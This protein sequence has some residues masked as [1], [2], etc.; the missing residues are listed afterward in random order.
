MLR[1][2]LR[3]HVVDA[4]IRG[5]GLGHLAGI[6]RDHHGP[7]PLSPETGDR[8]RR[9]LDLGGRGAAGGVLVLTRPFAEQYR[10]RI[11]SYSGS[12]LRVRTA[13]GAADVPEVVAAARRI[14]GENDSFDTISLA[15]E[16]EAARSA[17]DV[18]AVALW[19]VAA[20][21]GLAGAVAVAIAL[22]RYMARAS[23]DQDVLRALGAR[24]GERW[25]ATFAT[26]VP[27]ALPGALVAGIAAWLASPLFP[28]GVARDAEPA[29]QSQV[30]ATAREQPDRRAGVVQRARHGSA[31]PAARA[32]DERDLA[33]K[34]GHA[35][36]AGLRSG[37]RPSPRSATA[38]TSS[39]RSRRG[40]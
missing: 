35:L 25:A 16:G 5:D 24:P 23:A 30:L 34:R 38:G 19:L 20:V 18:T 39:A 17:I 26:A 10:D 15:V 4:E 1:Q 14:F 7:E 13:H 22:A 31:D 6:A 27:I 33:V 21:A 37:R 40:W 3:A 28:I 12:V 36:P 32:G 2:H 29:F 11:G 8:L 9:P